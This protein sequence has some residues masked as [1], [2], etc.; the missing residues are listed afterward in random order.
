MCGDCV[1]VGIIGD[2]LCRCECALVSDD[3]TINGSELG[4]GGTLR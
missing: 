2:V 3:S 4:T 1:D